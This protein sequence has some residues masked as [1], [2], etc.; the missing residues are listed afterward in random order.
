MVSD[1]EEIG[2]T[3]DIPHQLVEA[4][5][6][7]RAHKGVLYID[8]INTLNLPSQQ[9]LLTAIQEKEFQIT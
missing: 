1:S 5:A 8:E 6:I 7:H 4:G 9:H 3:K 2:L